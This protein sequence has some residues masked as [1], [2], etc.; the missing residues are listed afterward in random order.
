[1]AQSSFALMT[2]LGRAKEAAALANGEPIVITHIA[3]GDGMTVPSGG[4]TALYSEVARKTISG[5]GTV[6]GASNVAFFDCFLAAEEG[7]FTIREAGLYDD[8]GDLIAIARYDPP[9][10]KPVPASGQTVEGTIRLEVAFSNVANVQIVI[11]PSMQVALQRLTRLPW[12]PVIS[13]ATAAPPASPAIGA[14]YLVPT[15]ATGSWAGHAGK[16]AEFTVA[17]WALLTPPN[18][19]GISL[20][21]GRIFERIDGAYVEKIARDVQSGKWS[22][23][24]A[25]GTPNALAVVLTPPIAQ[26]TPGMTV[27][28]KT[29]SKN[30][31]AATLNAGAGAA[32]IRRP[33]GS[34]LLDGDLAGGGVY[35]FV[36]DGANWVAA[37]LEPPIPLVTNVTLFVRPDGSN[38]NDG[39]ANTAG[40]AFQTI[41]YAMDHVAARYVGAYRVTIQLATGTY[42]P[43]TLS[44]TPMLDIELR[45]NPASPTDVVIQSSGSNDAATANQYGRLR[46]DGVTLRGGRNLICAR[47]FATID[48]GTVRLEDCSQS[49]ILATFLALITGGTQILARGSATNFL[50]AS[51]SR[52]NLGGQVSFEAGR[53]YSN[54]TVLANGGDINLAGVSFT[55][56][57]PTARRY[58]A[59]VNGSIFT[60]GGGANFIPGTTPGTVD[61]GGTY[62]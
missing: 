48:I 47:N 44:G 50:T 11:D 56:S 51:Y 22:Y 8:D 34:E 29:A 27:K 60:G 36:F 15:G 12:I 58:A 45:G 1:M 13:M 59:N 33:S 3:I 31:G 52:I 26:Y 21:D 7:P 53:S 55:G 6:V 43:F 2:N 46:L 38:S 61:S 10:N 19:H 62:L 16:I 23:A 5:H 30:T 20:P 32:P 40:R 28:V 4:E 42:A 54:A 57:P 18:G 49:Q 24:V 37:Q 14:T 17:G 39:G 41:Q 25:T 9:I 35:T